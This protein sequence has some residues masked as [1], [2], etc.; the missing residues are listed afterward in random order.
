MNISFA[1]FWDGFQ[2]NNN[3]FIDLLKTI[4]SN[5][6]LV[7]FSNE[8]EILIYSCFGHTHHHA[9]RSKVKKIFYTGENLR[10]NFNECD[11]S[12]TF[13]FDSYDGRN[14][15]LPLWMLQI[16]W[17]NKKDFCS[18]ELVNESIIEFPLVTK[19]SDVISAELILISV[20][21]SDISWI[22]K[23]IEGSNEVD[24]KKLY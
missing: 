4:N 24:L 22:N 7:P 13:D 16:D 8:T 10:P 6:N 2:D 17:F 15:R 3:F 1:D 14:I 5:F 12:L 9:N 21:S 19:L 11:Y 18:T 23:F 20:R